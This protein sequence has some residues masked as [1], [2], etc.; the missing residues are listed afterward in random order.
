MSSISIQAATAVYGGETL[1]ETVRRMAA[2]TGCKRIYI[3]ANDYGDRLAHTDFFRVER[4]G[5][6][7]RVHSSATV[8]RL[9][10]VFDNGTFLPL[11]EAS[12]SSK[13]S[14]LQRFAYGW[15]DWWRDR[16]Q[17]DR[18]VL[19]SSLFQI[20][21]F[22]ALFL[23]N[24]AEESGQRRAARLGLPQPEIPWRDI[25]FLLECTGGSLLM[26]IG[27][28]L[29]TGPAAYLIWSKLLDERSGWGWLIYSGLNM[30]VALL[31]FLNP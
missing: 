23:F 22:G 10:L 29:I 31:L 5:D 6:E 3:Y 25:W 8:H 19:F 21:G 4:P 26:L 17:D 18:A 14:W 1:E 12:P 2:A 16:W 28:S 20:I 30:G 9:E 24:V 13:I 7:E 27:L 11:N 15:C